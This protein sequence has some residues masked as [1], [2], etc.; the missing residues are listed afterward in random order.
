MN[1]IAPPGAFRMST[2]LA[3]YSIFSAIGVLPMASTLDDVAWHV[4]SP[5]KRQG[6]E[7]SD[8]N[9]CARARPSPRPRSLRRQPVEHDLAAVAAAH[10]LEA[11]QEPARR[12]AVGD[13][14]AHVEPALEHGDHLMPGL[15]H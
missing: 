1:S 5:R 4:M 3:R 11:F 2:L 13:D 8:P 14:L 6:V 12:Q 15:E 7:K 9:I 10:G